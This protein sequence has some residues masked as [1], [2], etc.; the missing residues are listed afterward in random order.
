M[1]ENEVLAK[2][3]AELNKVRCLLHLEQERHAE[4]IR[5]LK[6]THDAE[7]AKL[8]EENREMKELANARSDT[9]VIRDELSSST[10]QLCDKIDELQSLIS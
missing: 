10:R 4:E 6:A 1:S 5:D 3:N 7:L 9:T 2:Y 8:K